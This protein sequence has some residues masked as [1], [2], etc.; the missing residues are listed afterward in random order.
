[1]IIHNHSLR[2]RYSSSS[3][4]SIQR[5]QELRKP[6]LVHGSGVCQAGPWWQPSTLVRFQRPCSRDAIVKIES[7][8]PLRA[9]TELEGTTLQSIILPQFSQVPITTTS[10]DRN[11]FPLRKHQRDHIWWKQTQSWILKTL[12][13]ETRIRGQLT[14]KL[15]F[16]ASL[17]QIWLGAS[18]EEVRE[19]PWD[20]PL[21]ALPNA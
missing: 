6:T 9:R 5:L 12:R 8:S 1:M 21:R 19:L 4:S 16:A 18:I 20:S 11:L 13:K 15:A 10:I 3:I 14:L 2:F 17:A 7:F